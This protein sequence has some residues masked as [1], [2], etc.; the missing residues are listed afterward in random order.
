M[1]YEKEI[2]KLNKELSNL[3]IKEINKINKNSKIKEIKRKELKEIKLYNTLSKNIESFKIT[4]NSI[5]WYIC[6]PTV[7]DSPHIGHARTYILFDT[8]RNI[9][10]EYFKIEVIYTMNITDIDDKIIKK[11]YELKN[12][13]NNKEYENISEKKLAKI[14]T[15]KYTKEFFDDLEKLNVRRPTFITKVSDYIPEIISFIEKIISKGKAY[16]SNGSV[17]FDMEKYL[18]KNDFKFTNKEAVINEQTIN[19]EKKN[20]DKK[21]SLDFVLWK[22][23]ADKINE[24]NYQSP[25]GL[26][27]PGWHIE[28]S[29][30]ATNIFG[31]DNSLDIHSGGID[32]KFPHHENEIIQSESISENSFVR[33]FLHSGHLEIDGR[34]MSKSL[35]NFIKISELLEKFDKRVIRLSFLLSKYNNTCKY[36]EDSLIYAEKLLNKFLN[37]ISYVESRKED[38][39]TMNEENLKIFEFINEKKEEVDEALRDNFN[40]PRT[41]TILENLVGILNN[42]IQKNDKQK[43]EIYESVLRVGS[44]FVKRILKIYGIEISVKNDGEENEKLKILEILGNYRK[45]VRSLAKKKSDFKEF[46]VISDDVRQQLTEIGFILEDSGKETI[47]RKKL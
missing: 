39:K 13:K 28:C 14:V 41:L 33:Y 25:W 40:I 11:A 42:E 8:I 23:T 10:E 3:N 46:Y 24:L 4:N 15:E 18:E 26:G 47:I 31:E 16:V 6:G 1:E 32:L 12:S 19:S 45:S 21:N 22:N 34:K 27:R 20:S 38:F 30:M 9:F 43:N 36:E 5:K 17:Y 37:F 7:Y 2:N 35:K 44:D 29:V